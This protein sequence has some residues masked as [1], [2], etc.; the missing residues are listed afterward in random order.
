MTGEAGRR[1]MSMAPQDL[2]IPHFLASGLSST[3]FQFPNFTEGKG[4]GEE[5]GVHLFAVDFEG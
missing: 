4:E 5:E 2:T 3:A 1:W